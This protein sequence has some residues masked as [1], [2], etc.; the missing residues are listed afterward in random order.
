MSGACGASLAATTTSRTIYSNLCNQ[1]ILPHGTP[2]QVREEVVRKIRALAP[3]GGYVVSGGHNVQADVGPENIL[4]LF[5][6]AWQVV[7]YPL[8]DAAADRVAWS[9]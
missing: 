6:T 2:E 8:A 1:T 3:G 9:A 7:W 5:D 4:T